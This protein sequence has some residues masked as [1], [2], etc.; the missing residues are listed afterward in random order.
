MNMASN[1]GHALSNSGSGFSD[2]RV[3]RYLA[4][5]AGIA[6]GYAL[7]RGSHWSSSIEFH[8][9]MEIFSMMVAWTVGV[10]ALVRYYA[11][12]STR[13]LFIGA[14]FLGTAFMDGYH[15]VVTSLNFIPYLPE[16]LPSMAPWSWLASRI[17]LSVMILLSATLTARRY[18]VGEKDQ[19]YETAVYAGSFVLLTIT[20]LFFVFVPLPNVYDPTS[21]IHRPEELIPAVLFGI[22]IVA[23]LKKDGW[24]KGH[25]EHWLIISL[26]MN[27]VA[28]AL[29]LPFS[30]ILHDLEFDLAHGLKIASYMAALI[31]LLITTFAT[32][33][34]AEGSTMKM[35]SAIEALR[36]SDSRHQL[37]IDLI[38]DAIYLQQRGEIIFVN[39]AAVELFGAESENDLIGRQ[40]ID[41]STPEY[42]ERIRERQRLIL[43]NNSTMPFFETGH[44]KFD[45]TE[46]V[47]EGAAMPFHWDNV[48]TTLVVIRDITD[49]KKDKDK[50]ASYAKD[51]ERSNADLEQFAYV[52]SHD[53]KAPLRSI[54]NLAQWIEEDL[55]ESLEGETRENMDLLRNRVNRMTALLDDLLQ[56]SRAGKDSSDA[57]EIDTDELVQDIVDLQDIPKGYTVT[58][59][60]LPTAIVRKSPLEV[61]LRNL[62]SNAVKHHDRDTGSIE[63]SAE[64]LDDRVVFSVSDDGPGIPAEFHKKIFDMFRTLKPRDQVEGS[65]MGLAVVRK[66][67]E[68]RGGVMQVHSNVDERGTRF[69]FDWLKN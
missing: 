62:I 57:V 4:I 10:L 5:F 1:I 64:D 67:V 54:E 69:V 39:P 32:L 63:I 43:E 30:N 29:V 15:G 55:E 49:A 22:S 26:L 48:E 66:L 59:S 45:G 21:F 34:E 61:V 6:L 47:T 51:L 31:G 2:R 42:R 56:Y 19:S 58:T 52:A 60:N 37:L 33:R 35:Q 14:G 65:G 9:N 68:R 50:L 7:I 16:D 17:F 13:F 24:K 23:Y 3:V 20:T 46:I 40:S 18:A 53:L 36:A 27:F 41:L 8:T 11:S 38:P 44:I 12:R 28:Q 25:F